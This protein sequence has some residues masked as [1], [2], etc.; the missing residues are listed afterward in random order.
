MLPKKNRGQVHITD[1]N[2]N[3]YHTESKIR[4]IAQ[5]NIASSSRAGLLIFSSKYL[6]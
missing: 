2:N 1:N 5:Y 3:N 6:I 4:Q